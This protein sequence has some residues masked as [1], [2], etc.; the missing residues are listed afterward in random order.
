MHL[1]DFSKGML[2]AFGIVGAGIPIATGA[3]LSSV[4]RGTNQV[5][6]SFLGDGAINEG[7]F[8]ES[9]NMASLWKLPV[10]YVVE[11]NQYALSMPNEL[12]SAVTALSTRGCSYNVP[13]RTVDWEQCA[14][15]LQRLA[16]GNR[17]RKK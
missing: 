10:I 4:V 6:V 2:G 14:G 11:N 13:G 8:H 1:C 7:V 9:L 16:A 3:A 12:E 5:A 15:G 17:G